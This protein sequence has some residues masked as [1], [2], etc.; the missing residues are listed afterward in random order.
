MLI[1]AGVFLAFLI[2]EAAVRLFGLG[3]PEFYAYS[4]ARGWKMRAG[5]QGW[6]TD[7]GHAF[8]RVNRWG[9]R[10]P[11][12]S[13]EKPPGTL[14]VAVLG[15]SFVEAQQVPEE[16]TVCAVIERELT[17]SLPDFARGRDKNIKRV[18]I[19][20]FGVDGYGTAQEFFTLTRDVWQFSPDIV[21][22]VFF[23]G[24]DVRNNSVV[25]E[26]DKCRP[27]FAP[28]DGRLVLGGPFEDSPLFRLKCVMRF[29]SYDSQL[30]NILG[31]ARSGLRAALRRLHARDSPAPKAD[32]RHNETSGVSAREPGV[33]DLIYRPPTDPTWRQA[34]QISEG[35]IEMIARDSAAHGAL[36]LAVVADTGAQTQPNPAVQARYL[37]IIG[38]GDLFYPNHRID[39]LG[40]RDG[41]AVAD[42]V[43]A[44]SSYARAHNVYFHGFPNTRLG[45]GHWNRR[46]NCFAGVLIAT[47]LTAMMASVEPSLNLGSASF[48]DGQ[49]QRAG[50]R[51]R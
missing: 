31:E 16:I 10:G 30:L 38:G 23:P 13:R 42:L 28:D 18:E 3:K 12:W 46:G 26:G 40:A 29:E 9:Y 20:N 43:P 7:E 39:A 25:L 50:A 49:I 22:L 5:A 35:E 27:F 36:F 45:T 21:V 32:G 11:E 24:N 41:F 48:D 37:N 15:D 6:Q 1:V 51:C 47:K 4:A 34:W 19:M 33:N 44:M 17:N 8:I 14:R 2:A